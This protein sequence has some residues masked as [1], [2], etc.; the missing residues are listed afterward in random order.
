MR[1]L[2]IDDDPINRLY[3][4]AVLSPHGGTVSAAS[5]EQGLEAF[6]KAL[7]AGERFDAVLVD[8]RMPRMDGHRT[9]QKI[10]TIE[11]DAGIPGNEETAV[12]MVSAMDDAR[13]VNQAFFQGRAMSFLP[14][15]VDPD[16][17]LE[18]LRKFGLLG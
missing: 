11:H 18:E 17:L 12:I 8:I 6:S 7:S 5:G 16:V 10:R 1:A 14:K 13:N 15:P 9:L 2:I 4:E 3:L